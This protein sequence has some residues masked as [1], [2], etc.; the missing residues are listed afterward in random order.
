MLCG[1]G[2]SEQNKEQASNAKASAPN[3]E[4]GSIKPSPEPPKDESKPAPINP[5]P[6]PPKKNPT[7]N[8]VNPT[9]QPPKK[10]PTPNPVNPTPQ[11]PKKKPNKP[12]GKPTGGTTR[13]GQG[14][15]PQGQNN[16]GKKP[17][18]KAGGQ[19][20]SK[21]PGNSKA[22][23][24]QIFQRRWALLVGTASQGQWP[25]YQVVQQSLGKPD[26]QK[27]N[28]TMN[29]KAIL[30]S[31][32]KGAVNP[33]ARNSP[34]VARCVRWDYLDAPKGQQSIQLYFFN[35][36]LAGFQLVKTGGK[37]S[38]N[39]AGGQGGKKQPGNN[40]P[41]GFPNNRPKGGS[42]RQKNGNN[43]G[44]QGGKKQP[45]NGNR[46]RQNNGFNNLGGK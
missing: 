38:G 28:V 15:K 19:G 1:C 43:A 21:Q 33:A 3:G 31:N 5:T 26:R 32:G 14:S 8:P 2:G 13:P 45:G 29:T 7:P 18:N 12:A 40:R 35:G 20:A 30:K 27:Q 22:Q 36:S 4:P 39:K 46:L 9:P 24:Q 10:N 44:G 42:Q 25:N 17:G 11:P 34:N 41:G 23:S 6:Q 16:A 37:Q